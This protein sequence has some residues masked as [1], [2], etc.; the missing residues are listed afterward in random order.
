MKSIRVTRTNDLRLAPADAYSQELIN[1]LKP[2][3]TY[4]VEIKEDR[5]RGTLNLYW[6]G[7]GLLVNNYSG[8]GGGLIQVNGRR[9]NPAA[10]WP[11]SRKYH[12]MLMKATGHVER[13][14]WID[15]SL[16]G[17][18]GWRD[19]V[20]SIALEAM[21]ED[22]FNAYFEQA[23]AITFS[24]FDWNPWDQ[25]KLDHPLPNAQG[26]WRVIDGTARSVTR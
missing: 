13:V 19:E 25:W 11:T 12:Q 7:V 5:S 1:G 10:L 17:G 2:G 24:L 23:Q 8:P 6:A 21:E 16:P 3:K 18:I 14:Y 26:Q 20:D 9:Y 22:E 15:R 4:K